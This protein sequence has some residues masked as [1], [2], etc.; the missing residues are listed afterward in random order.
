M[1]SSEAETGRRRSW[2]RLALQVL[3]VGIIASLLGLLVR[4]TIVRG[5][6][7]HLVS[8]VKVGARPTAPQFELPVLWAQA[9]TWPRSIRLAIS[10][11]RLSIHEPGCKS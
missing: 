6:G 7:T 5:A 2:L 10:D 3:A 4:Q 8:E 1:M 11:G 9:E